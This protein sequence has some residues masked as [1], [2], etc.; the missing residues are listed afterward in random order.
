MKWKLLSAVAIIASQAGAEN[1]THN[2]LPAAYQLW[3]NGARLIPPRGAN[4]IQAVV[5][6]GLAQ[7]ATTLQ[8]AQCHQTHR[9]LETDLYIDQ[10]ELARRCAQCHIESGKGPREVAAKP[11]QK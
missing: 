4:D 9:V 10:A 7:S 3:K 6:R 5:A 8:C 11:A 1:H 2:S